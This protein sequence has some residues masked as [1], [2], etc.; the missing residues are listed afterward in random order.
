MKI[1]VS[2]KTSVYMVGGGGVGLSHPCD[3]HVYVIEN[4]GEAALIDAGSGIAP[5]QIRERVIQDGIALS[6]IKTIVLTHSHWDHGRGAAW[7]VA[8]TGARLAV[9]R[10]GVPTLEETLWPASHVE[11]HGAA[12]R[13]VPVQLPLEDGDEIRVGDLVLTVIHTP[14]HSDDSISLHAQAGG[15]SILFGGDTCFAEGGHGTVN[16]DTDFRAYRAS[17]RRL[18]A[19]KIDVLFPGHKHFVLSRAFAHISL[20]E[21]KMSG[22]WT[23]VVASRVPFFPTWW[24]EHDPSLYDD[25]RNPV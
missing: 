5:Q 21:R 23:D 3:S 13:P 1:F 14:G 25:A 20:L 6:S 17:V 2:G 22:G 16:A 18:D 24:L 7:W 11:R 12:S 8:E 9:H 19:M 4:G 10:L 15:Q